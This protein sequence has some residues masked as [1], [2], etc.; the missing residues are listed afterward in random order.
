M[1]A[2]QRILA[3]D[4]GKEDIWQYNGKVQVTIPAES[5]LQSFKPDN[6]TVLLHK[7]IYFTPTCQ[8]LLEEDAA[9]AYFLFHHRQK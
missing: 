5:Q 3:F 1:T 6:I 7:L 2:V 4:G 8:Y 9:A